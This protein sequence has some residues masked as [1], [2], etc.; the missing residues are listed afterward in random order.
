MAPNTLKE[1]LLSFGQ[2]IDEK[3]SFAEDTEK[4]AE[5]TEKGAEDTEKGAEDTE[6]GAEDT[7][8]EIMYKSHVGIMD[9]IMKWRDDGEISLESQQ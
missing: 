6:K 4:G 7:N 2:S 3:V 5:D 9:T 1:Q 8:S